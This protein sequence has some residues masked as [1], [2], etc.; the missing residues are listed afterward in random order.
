MMTRELTIYSPCTNNSSSMKAAGLAS[1]TVYQY[2][3]LPVMLWKVILKWNEHCL[4]LTYPHPYLSSSG[5]WGLLVIKFIHLKTKLEW[6]Q[7]D[8]IYF[9][10]NRIRRSER[11]LIEAWKLKAVQVISSVWMLTGEQFSLQ[12]TNICTKGCHDKSWYFLIILKISLQINLSVVIVSFLVRSLSSV[13]S[14][15]LF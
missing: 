1:W 6:N 7:S 2:H 12:A 13:R 9:V 4:L 14:F 11:N 15:F 5:P 8:M 3:R 10:L